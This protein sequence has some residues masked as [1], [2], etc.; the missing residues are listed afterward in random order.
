MEINTD[1]SE[2]IA[3]S[4]LWLL[5]G[6]WRS[7]SPTPIA[8]ST[9]SVQILASK[10]ILH[11]KVPEFPSEKAG[12]WAEGEKIQDA[13][14]T[15]VLE[16]KDDEGIIGTCKKDTSQLDVLPLGKLGMVS[17]SV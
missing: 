17:A 4:Q 3:L 1:V 10:Y 7:D 16:S 12:S 15:L 5:R 9:S 13:S 6:P 2:Y 14:R 8:M 11:C